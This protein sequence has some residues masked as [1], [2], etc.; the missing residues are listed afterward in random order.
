[1]LIY[2]MFSCRLVK[3]NKKG[4][5]Q[6][7]KTHTSMKNISPAVSV[8]A[9]TTNV[10]FLMCR[11]PLGLIGSSRPLCNKTNYLSFTHHLILICLATGLYAIAVNLHLTGSYQM[12]EAV[13]EFIDPL[14][15]CEANVRFPHQTPYLLPD[16]I[17]IDLENSE[18]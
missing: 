18:S 3:L 7:H 13:Q 1:M 16:V 10:C 14:T 12:C 4:G 5:T 9:C 17:F 8:P 15:V 11:L 6:T 2:N